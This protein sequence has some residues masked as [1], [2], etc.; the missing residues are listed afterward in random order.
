MVYRKIENF[1]DNIFFAQDFP[2]FVFFV[3]LLL[4]ALLPLW[5]PVW[6]VS[7]YWNTPSK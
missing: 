7:K 6:F 4:F 5:Y 3:G 1:I 2:P